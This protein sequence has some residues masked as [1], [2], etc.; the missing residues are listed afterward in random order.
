MKQVF[1]STLLVDLI[2]CVFFITALAIVGKIDAP[3]TALYCVI[4]AFGNALAPTLIGV[5]IFKLINKKTIL[6][7]KIG[8]KLFQAIILLILFLV[9]ICLWSVT[10]I[11]VFYSDLSKITIFRIEQDFQSQFSG[12]L[13]ILCIHAVIIP[14]VYDYL[15][16]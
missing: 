3:I 7:S 1:F 16:E 13:P 2:S 14:V 8:T 6:T 15:N 5:L 9:G 12:Y 11:V 4:M 10:D